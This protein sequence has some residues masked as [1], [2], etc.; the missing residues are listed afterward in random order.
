MILISGPDNNHVTNAPHARDFEKRIGK[1]H[2][3]GLRAP[4][5]FVW[6]A[7]GV[8]YILFSGFQT[9]DMLRSEFIMAKVQEHAQKL[10]VKYQDPSRGPPDPSFVLQLPDET[11]SGSNLYAIQKS[12]DGPFQFDVFFESASA[13]Q[14]LTCMPA[15]AAR[16]MLFL[17]SL[18]CQ[19]PRLRMVL[20]PLKNSTTIVSSKP[21]PSQKAHQ[22]NWSTSRKLSPVTL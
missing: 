21:S 8:T 19:L 15:S 17:T 13:K 4:P 5:G 14:P 9:T 16:E 20:R 2:F 22:M 11:L 1:T 7:R 3:L 10:I 12:F 6:K 18:F